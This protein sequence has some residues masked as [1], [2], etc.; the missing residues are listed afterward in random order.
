MIPRWLL[1]VMALVTLGV[2]V[3]DY[4][5]QYFIAGHVSSPAL[6]TLAGSV[7]GAAFLLAKG[8]KSDGGHRK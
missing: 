3:F 1:V 4:G 8:D 5:A 6:T 7:C 2:F